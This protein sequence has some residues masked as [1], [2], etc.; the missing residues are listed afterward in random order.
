MNIKFSANRLLIVFYLFLIACSETEVPT[1]LASLA[2]IEAGEDNSYANIYRVSTKHLHLDLDVNFENKSI[3][4]IARHEIENN[5][6]DTAI[7]DIKGL[8][9]QKVTLGAKGKEKNTSY[10][11]GIEDS[12]NGAPL[13]VLITP[14]TRYINIYYQT[15]DQTTSLHWNNEKIKPT[16]SNDSIQKDSLVGSSTTPS[17][18]YT[19]PGEQFIRNWIPLQDIGYRKINYSA[20]VRVPKG[21]LPL[22]GTINPTK[23]NDSSTYHFSSFSPVSIYD[24]GLTIGNFKHKKLSDKIG[25]YFIQKVNKTIIKETKTLPV[26]FKNIEKTYGKSPWPI[27]N[28]IVLP[29]SSP[30]HNYTYPCL[31]FIHPSIFSKYEN[32]TY[33]L[34]QFLLS[35]W[36]STFFSTSCKNNI[37]LETGISNYYLNRFVLQNYGK[38]Q[39]ELASKLYINTCLLSANEDFPCQFLP[40]NVYTINCNEKSDTQTKEIAFKQL[41]G[42]LLMKSLETSLGTVKLDRFVRK[43]LQENQIHSL[44]D[45]ERELNHYLVQEEVIR[46]PLKTWLYGKK[47]PSFTY[48]ISSKR[49]LQIHVFIK[50]FL[51][52]KRFFRLRKTK[53]TFTHFTQFDWL[54]FISLLPAK[55]DVKKLSQLDAQ[56]HLSY[57][58]NRNIQSAWIKYGL[59]NNYAGVQTALQ[60]VLARYGDKVYQSS[61][62]LDKTL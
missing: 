37:S 49:H 34:E 17:Y 35:H 46:F 40:A 9:I 47:I 25:I 21:L 20:T 42:Y 31:Y 41:K 19:L 30:F 55:T 12:T 27:T 61:F 32:S 53:V 8:Q 23:K 24:I 58:P 28:L 22:M 43:Y 60:G 14:K 48:K 56:Y 18:V 5:H 45:F 29:D 10:I 39:A 4:G 33:D 6:A 54:T 59:K 38:E 16:F 3:Y 7:F 57:H 13:S 15:T 62:K 11:I 36:P 51:S 2:S 50:S 44:A 1:K 26:I 52:N